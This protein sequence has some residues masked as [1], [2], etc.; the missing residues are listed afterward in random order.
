MSLDTRPLPP[1]DSSAGAPAPTATT[2]AQFPNPSASGSDST[3]SK[4]S[5][6]N[7]SSTI[8]DGNAAGSSATSTATISRSDP[9]SGRGGVTGNPTPGNPTVTSSN[10]TATP[11][12]QLGPQSGNPAASSTGTVPVDTLVYISLGAIVVLAAIAA[13]FFRH[14][15]AQV[16]AAH[17]SRP[18]HHASAYERILAQTTAELAATA[19]ATGAAAH[20]S[21]YHVT[22]AMTPLPAANAGAVGYDRDD[23]FDDAGMGMVAAAGLGGA[24]AATCHSNVH[25]VPLAALAWSLA[26]APCASDPNNGG[27]SLQ[28]IADDWTA[29]LLALER[30]HAPAASAVNPVDV[31]RRSVACAM[32]GATARLLTR[33]GVPDAHVPRPGTTGPPAGGG[34]SR[35]AD[36]EEWAL[37]DH[38]RDVLSRLYAC[39]P[40]SAIVV[41]GPGDVPD[42]ALPVGTWS[43]Y[44]HDDDAHFSMD[45]GNGATR[46]E[47]MVA[48][49]VWPGWIQMAQHQQQ[50]QISADRALLP[51]RL[52]LVRGS[53][54]GNWSPV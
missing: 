2:T 49:T 7:F 32:A 4:S 5:T 20:N 36:T 6:I 33:L 51:A 25:V 42:A 13:L 26:L 3:N 8:V 29:I 54:G 12:G 9:A 15:R 23:Y 41:V 38:A 10:P 22:G 11:G 37:V 47:W 17:R 39:V 43:A 35:V 31:Q 24:A 44:L 30:V 34:I 46:G 48:A 18:G 52:H 27:D 50:H 45:F 19:S 1:L 40:T 16:L 14:R 21:R 53:G 28:Q